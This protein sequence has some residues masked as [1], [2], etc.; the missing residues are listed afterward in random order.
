MP[1]MA[2]NKIRHLASERE[3][4][5]GGKMGITRFFHDTLGAKLKN[6]YWSWGAIDPVSNRVFLRVWEDQIQPAGDRERVEIYW[7]NPV[8]KSSGNAERG[9]HLEVIKNGAQ[10][11]GI[12]CK[13][14]DPHTTE[15]P[16]KIKS[17]DRRTLLQLGDFT[18]DDRCIY[19]HIEARISISE[20]ALTNDLRAIISQKTWD[21]TTVQALVDARVGQGKFRADVLQLWNR[22]CAV[23]GSTT[24]DA[25]RASHIKPWRD[26]TNKERLDSTN[27]LPLVASLDA[28]FDAGL[29]SFEDSGRML[30]SSKLSPSEREIYGIVG[31][32]LTTK[33]LSKT[34]TYLL[35]HRTTL[36]FK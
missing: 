6:T 21:S 20:L 7:K 9:G 34:A 8:R 17:F 13:A 29:I 18:E 36:Y 33:P 11:I 12:V 15:A 26:S 16:K 1:R 32:T 24:I 30:V 2:L 35:Y 10:G 27:G 19:A 25:I 14:R 31:K 22:R 23:T 28:L 4:I 3:R 5:A